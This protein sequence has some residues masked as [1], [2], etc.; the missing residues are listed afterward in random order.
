MS[1]RSGAKRSA[2]VLLQEQ[3]ER[4]E[5]D[6]VRATALAAE[7]AERAAKRR[8]QTKE[9]FAKT[10]NMHLERWDALGLQHVQHHDVTLP[11]PAPS[12]Y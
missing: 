7:E 10:W 1:R 2:S 5:D 3:A 8:K 6:L 11:R 12:V 4:I 9:Q